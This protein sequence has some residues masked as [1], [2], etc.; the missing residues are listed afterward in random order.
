ML[1]KRKVATISLTRQDALEPGPTAVK[2]S[3]LGAEWLCVTPHGGAWFGRL[4]QTDFEFKASFSN[5]EVLSNSVS[6]CL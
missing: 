6:P 5:G 3:R 4:R 1:K 2:D